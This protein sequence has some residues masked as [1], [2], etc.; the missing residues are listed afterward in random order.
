MGERIAFQLDRRGRQRP[1]N[2]RGDGHLQLHGRRDGGFPQGEGNSVAIA[3]LPTFWPCF[4]DEIA[5]AFAVWSA[6]ANIQFTE[7]QDNGAPF[8]AA[9]AAGDIRIAAHGFDGPSNILA[10]GFFPPPNGVSAA[11][12]IHFDVAENWS[13]TPGTGVFDFGIVAIHEIGHAIGLD[14]ET[15]LGG[16][17]DRRS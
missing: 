15:R 13:C 9:I 7:V 16:L 10:H 1:S 6:I 3:S 8:N 2:S 11:G 12:D 14:H 17:A 5:S 4:I